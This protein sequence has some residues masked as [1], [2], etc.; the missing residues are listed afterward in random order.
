M[1]AAIVSPALGA[2]GVPSPGRG[3]GPGLLGEMPGPDGPEAFRPALIGEVTRELRPLFRP[4][5]IE[6]PSRYGL[7]RYCGGGGGAGALG[8]FDR[9]HMAWLPLGQ[10]WFLG[11]DF[12]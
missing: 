4:V 1:P 7:W 12:L 2:T 3:R 5:P 6:A 11:V 8:V 10:D 9:M